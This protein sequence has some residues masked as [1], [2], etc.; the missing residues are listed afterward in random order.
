MLEERQPPTQA[1]DCR[2][3]VD[4]GLRSHLQKEDNQALYSTRSHQV[5]L[6]CE[7]KLAPQRYIVLAGNRRNSLLLPVFC[8]LG[9]SLAGSLLWL[10]LESSA[11]ALGAASMQPGTDGLYVALLFLQI[12]YFL[13]AAPMVRRAG[14]QCLESVSALV[15]NKAGATQGI[16]ERLSGT[17][18]SGLSR[19]LLPA[20]ALVLATQEVQFARFSRW[21]S[22]PDWA[23]GELWA[24]LASWATWTIAFWLIARVIVDLNT[25][26][27]LG[28]DCVVIDIMRIEPLVAFSR[29]GLQ[30]TG[31]IV[32]I[33]ALW[34]ISAVVLTAYLSPENPG[35][36]G[37]IVLL[38]L[39]LY[40]SIT[41]AAF[42]YPQLGIRANM[43][44]KKLLVSEQI[45]CQLP[46]LQGKAISEDTDL[47]RLASLLAIRSH[48]QSLPD[49]PIGQHARVRLAL[50]LLIPLLSW[51][52]A[53]VVEE[54][55][56]Q[57][58]Q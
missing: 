2:A 9:C 30:L 52:A 55:V 50:Y 20:L 5:T 32:G 56:S 49:W 37:Q 13:A 33:V 17:G 45:T 39:A 10:L 18:K 12:G 22:Q 19:A 47:E 46:Y 25:I 11:K 35:N 8:A 54:L 43:R 1:L 36:S 16:H 51:V 48:I 7:C 21:W 53:A 15:D 27:R 42:I 14:Q 44:A 3:L 26:R 24:V 6:R 29:Y 31:L 58:W 34:A 40:L 28:R 23:L 38:M 41:I 4:T 57:L